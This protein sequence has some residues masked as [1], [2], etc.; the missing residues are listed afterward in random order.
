MTTGYDELSTLMGTFPELMV[1]R[2]FR[3]LAAKVLLCMQAELLDVEDD[4]EVIRQIELED[5]SKHALL[6]S[7][8]KVNAAT[9]DNGANQRRLKVTEAQNKLE[10]YC[11]QP[12]ISRRVGKTQ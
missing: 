9:A 7:W 1:F 5:A 6:S 12:H 11:K 3:S 10:K 4:L 8:A 2:R